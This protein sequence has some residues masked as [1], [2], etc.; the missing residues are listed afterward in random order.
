MGVTLRY[1]GN[2]GGFEKINKKNLPMCASFLLEDVRP[3]VGLYL[4]VK[5][6]LAT[7]LGANDFVH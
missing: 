2:A 4:R 7:R 6:M 5:G 1:R 3:T